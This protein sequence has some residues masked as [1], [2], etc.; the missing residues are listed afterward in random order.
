MSLEKI[1][2]YA[3]GGGGLL[4]AL[5]MLIWF[6]AGIVR[7]GGL[8][9]RGADASCLLQVIF[10]AM[11]VLFIGVGVF[12]VPWLVKVGGGEQAQAF[13]AAIEAQD[14]DAAFSLLSEDLQTELRGRY[15]FRIWFGRLRLEDWRVTSSCSNPT[16]GRIDGS[17]RRIEDGKRI[18]I[19]F[20]VYKVFG[21]WKI[22][23]I[24]FQELGPAYQVGQANDL[25]CSGD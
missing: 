14:P 11:G 1:F 20:Y 21:E 7:H 6:F 9:F 4:V 10:F 5:A 2:L 16:E 19:T 3:F 22:Q 25:V 8:R 18:A 17:A 15:E 23:G 24:Y 12:F 13:M